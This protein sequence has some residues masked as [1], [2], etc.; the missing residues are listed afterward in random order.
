MALDVYVGSLTRYYLGDWETPIQ[1][2]ARESGKQVLRVEVA[3]KG[4]SNSDDVIKDPEIVRSYVIS[5]R[6]ALNTALGEYLSCPLDWD[7]T[8]TAPYFS[9]QLRW[10]N[11]S[12]LKLWAAYLEHPDL[13]RPNNCVVDWT[14]DVAFKRIVEDPSKTKYPN[15][16]KDPTTWLPADF[17]PLVFETEEANGH[18]TTFGSVAGLK[19]E[20]DEINELTWKADKATIEKWKRDSTAPSAPLEEGARFGFALLSVLSSIAL[21]RKLVMR[22]DG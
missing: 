9:E 7:E 18:T 13:I 6:N 17:K 12:S 14:K 3:N 21:E 22:L 8:S 11:L 4:E 5:W 20:L 15:L 19:D 10:D 2:Y 16:L 1:R